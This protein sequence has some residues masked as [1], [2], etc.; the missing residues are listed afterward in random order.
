MAMGSGDRLQVLPEISVVV[1]RECQERHALNV[2]NKRP[3]EHEINDLV[4][5]VVITCLPF[6][7]GPLE[8]ACT[9]ARAVWSLY[10]NLVE[11]PVIFMC[12]EPHLSQKGYGSLF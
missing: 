10:R 6:P 5:R 9:L 2:P 4:N 11:P 1:C 7:L 3:R 8:E 12:D